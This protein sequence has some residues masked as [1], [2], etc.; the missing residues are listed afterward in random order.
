VISAA[1]LKNVSSHKVLVKILSLA[2]RC[3]FRHCIQ[4]SNLVLDPVLILSWK[5]IRFVNYNTYIF[6]FHAVNYIIIYIYMFH[7]TRAPGGPGLPHYWGFVIT[8]RHIEL[9]RTPLD[10]WSAWC[11]DL[12]DNSQRLQATDI[13]APRGIRTHNPCKWAV[14]DLCLDRATTSISIKYM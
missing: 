13:H 8:L 5:C 4:P 7:G 10:K 6:L 14:A 1:E 2:Y 12:A 9:S 11:R 3:R